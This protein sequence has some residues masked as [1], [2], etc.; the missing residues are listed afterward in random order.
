MLYSASNVALFRPGIRSNFRDGFVQTPAQYNNYLKSGTEKG[1]EIGAMIVAGPSRLFE[2]G[3]GEGVIYEDPKVGPKAT[4]V[5][6]EFGLG[7][8][9]SKK[10]VEDDI[11]SVADQHARWLGNATRQTYDYRAAAFLDD[12]FTGTNFPD[13]NGQAWLGT[14]KTLI[15]TSSTYANRPTA[16]VGLS[17]TGIT[18]LLDLAMNAVD[19]N[20][21][22]I[23]VSPDTMVI[24]NN[25]G[26][27]A[28]A[29]QIWNSVL[30][31]FTAENQENSLRLMMKAKN[32]KMPSKEPFLSRYKQ[33]KKSYFLID[34]KLNDA[35]FDLVRPPDYEDDRDFETG[36][37]KYKVTTRIRIYGFD[38]I[39]WYGANPT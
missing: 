14:A 22:P 38:P 15:G 31:P 28:R 33:N 29:L 13:I 39:G 12:A 34:S 6:K 37:Y 23:E 26:D 20:G 5:D 16:D 32:G 18:A 4:A 7:I 21:D 3:D 36:A 24:G 8:T 27:Y 2:I 19:Q 10:A 1:I 17:I 35:Y 9:I 25:A 11:Y 30:E